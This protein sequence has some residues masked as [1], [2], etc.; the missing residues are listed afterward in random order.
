[1]DKSWLKEHSEGLIASSACLGGEIPR[2]ILNYSMDKAEE[3]LLS[4]LE[5]F[6]DDFYLELMS[7]GHEDQKIV[8]KALFELGQKHNVKLIATN[9]IHFIEKDDYEAHKLLIRIN[10]GKDDMEDSM[11]YTGN[12]YLKSYD[13]MLELFPNNPEVL[14]NTINIANSI[15]PINLNKSN[16]AIISYS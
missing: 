8:N 7:H 11:F 13:E 1:M 6:K 16:Y 14:E 4:Y 3:S 9:D 10:T 15:E 5:I 12:E 2:M